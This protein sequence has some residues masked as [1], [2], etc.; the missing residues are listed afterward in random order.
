[1][2]SETASKRSDARLRKQLYGR[3]AELLR[4]AADSADNKD[5][6]WAR[7]YTEEGLKLVYAAE[8]L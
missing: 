5:S 6:T 8:T 7:V 1:M 4:K 2:K 3:A